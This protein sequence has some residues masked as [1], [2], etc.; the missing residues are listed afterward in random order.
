MVSEDFWNMFDVNENIP[1]FLFFA[2]WLKTHHES[3]GIKNLLITFN[4]SVKL[5]DTLFETKG[6]FESLES[7]KINVDT[8]EE[9]KIGVL[10]LILSMTCNLRRLS[11]NIFT[12]DR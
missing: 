1:H 10:R 8:P 5:L 3:L 7:L 4:G 6:V 11:T 9:M 2:E 12:E